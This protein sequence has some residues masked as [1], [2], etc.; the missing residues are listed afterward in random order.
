MKQVRPVSCD[1]HW[2]LLLSIMI[3]WEQMAHDI[4]RIITPRRFVEIIQPVLSRLL[5][6]LETF[7]KDYCLL[8]WQ[9]WYIEHTLRLLFL[10][11]SNL[12]NTRDSV[13]SDFLTLRRELKIRRTAEYFWRNSRCLEIGWNTVS[14]VWYIFS[15]KAKTRNKQR[16]KMVKIYAN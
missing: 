16:N 14:S 7:L 3:W 5:F 1:L 11:T 4:D 9:K 6:H 15:I 2:L 13:S 12:S 8:K 10:V